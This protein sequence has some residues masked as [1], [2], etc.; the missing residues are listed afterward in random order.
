MPGTSSM[1]SRR[2]THKFAKRC[3]TAYTHCSTLPHL[4]DVR[5]RRG[6][7]DLE[8]AS[9]GTDLWR[10]D[11][12]SPHQPETD[13]T[14]D[15]TIESRRRQWWRRKRDQ[16]INISTSINAD[17]H[18]SHQPGCGAESCSHH[19]V[20]TSTAGHKYVVSPKQSTPPRS[21][22]HRQIDPNR[23]QAA[24]HI[25]RLVDLAPSVRHP[26]SVVNEG[27]S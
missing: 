24:R 16:R 20:D 3:A 21:V 26:I 8:H 13:Q 18:S 19:E 12:S 5:R 23:A 7:R 2:S 4:S 9:G 10:R 15:T 22:F 17:N 6:F 1:C 11:G 27:S 14:R 25:R